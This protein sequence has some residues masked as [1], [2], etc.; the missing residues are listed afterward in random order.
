MAA[1]PPA[2][3]LGQVLVL[4]VQ[5][6]GAGADAAAFERRVFDEMMPAARQTGPGWQLHLTRKNRGPHAGQY[7]LAWTLDGTA[8]NGK[9]I[10]PKGLPAGNWYQA[11]E[12]VGADKLGALPTVD[13]LAVHFI[14][15]LPDRRDAFDKFIAEKLNP[16]VG[17]LRPDLRLLYYKPA[18]GSDP[19][20]YVTIFALTRAS[21]DKYW[22]NG[23]DSDDLKT[24]MKS[25]QA[26]TGEMKTYLVDD[27]YA[28]GNL[29]AAV[30]ESKDW[31]DW[32]V[33]R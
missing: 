11:Y 14:K 9:A 6:L 15:V 2:M 27:S 30:Y 26:L 28:T 21:R 25:P 23:S 1:Q 13:V 19:G 20:A 32:V 16:T 4:S 18:G 5:D 29:A 7:L 3:T 10:V 24:A 22:P 17:T 31:G 8:L 12:L 33:V